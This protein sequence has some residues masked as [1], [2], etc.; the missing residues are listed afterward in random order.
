MINFFIGAWLSIVSLPGQSDTTSV[1]LVEW[2]HTTNIDTALDI[3]RYSIT[4]SVK[5]YK[6]Y[7]VYR[8]FYVPEGI[9]AVTYLVGLV[10]E[11]IPYRTFLYCSARDYGIDYFYHWGFSFIPGK[12]I[13]VGIRKY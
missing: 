5:D 1:V 13:G 4:D 2:W 6:I 3:T 7:S 11:K 10:I 12:P 9:P 8:V